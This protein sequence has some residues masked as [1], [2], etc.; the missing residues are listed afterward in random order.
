MFSLS[1]RRGGREG[2]RRGREEM[3]SSSDSNRSTTLHEGDEDAPLR[4][5]VYSPRVKALYPGGN[6]W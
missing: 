4:E 6:C 1:E 5:D 3:Y 2:G